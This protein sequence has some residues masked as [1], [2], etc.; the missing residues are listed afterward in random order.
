M[1]TKEDFTQEVE[2]LLVNNKDIDVM[3]AILRVCGLNN[4]EPEAAKRLLSLPLKEK[5]EAEAQKLGL[6]DRGVSSRACI[7][8]FFE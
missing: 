4:V 8:H 1:I 2:L 3:D 6:I 5:L 7:A